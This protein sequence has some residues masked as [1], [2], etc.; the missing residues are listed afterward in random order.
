MAKKTVGTSLPKYHYKVAG[1][2]RDWDWFDIEG[3]VFAADSAAVRDNIELL[4]NIDY[5][6]EEIVEWAVQIIDGEYL[7]PK[8]EPVP[9]IIYDEGPLPSWLQEHSAPWDPA[10]DDTERLNE[11]L[12]RMAAPEPDEKWIDMSAV[13]GKILTLPSS[14]SQFSSTVT[15]TN[16]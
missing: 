4:L 10:F 11:A 6:C 7:W 1:L 3:E 15:K 2:S 5:E 13:V 14:I 16:Y 8:G 9:S 12:K